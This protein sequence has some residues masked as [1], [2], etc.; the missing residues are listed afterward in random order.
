MNYQIHFPDDFDE[1]AAEI[2][3][4]GRVE[5]SVSVGGQPYA[6]ACYDPV[7]LAQEITQALSTGHPFAE[8]RIVV[9][10]LLIRPA[11]EATVAQLIEREFFH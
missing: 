3:A 5:L 4:S 11:I 7:R 2:E 1:H 10:P 9:V 6:I 8:H